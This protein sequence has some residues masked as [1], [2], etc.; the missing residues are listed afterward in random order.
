L[1]DRDCGGS[2]DLSEKLVGSTQ[3]ETLDVFKILL[4]T[5]LSYMFWGEPE[6]LFHNIPNLLCYLLRGP[7]SHKYSF[8]QI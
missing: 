5:E 2:L 4:H 7:T 3:Q 1:R 8:Q 6:D